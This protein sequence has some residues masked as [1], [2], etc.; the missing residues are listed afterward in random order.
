MFENIEFNFLT[1]EGAILL[2]LNFPKLK[3]LDVRNCQI[4]DF[5]LI[6]ISKGIE[7]L[8]IFK[9]GNDPYARG[10]PNN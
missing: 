5:G 7:R 2:G 4:N 6:A 1:D 3:E 8:R 10:S 9:G